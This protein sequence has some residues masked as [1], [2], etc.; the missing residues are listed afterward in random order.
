LALLLPFLIACAHPPPAQQSADA[1]ANAAYVMDPH[2]HARPTEAVIKHLD[3]DITV[4]MGSQRIEGTASYLL[5]RSGAT[6]IILDTDGLI[7]HEV[8]GN[9]GPLPFEM[10]PASLIGRP[11]RIALAPGTERIRV[12]YATGPG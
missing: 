4:H 3:L 1:G 2:S 11:L 5:Q 10:G 8:E 6:H 12:R 9:G 7:I